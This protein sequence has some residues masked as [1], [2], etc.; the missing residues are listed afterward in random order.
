[1]TWRQL[2]D[3]G[4]AIGRDHIASTVY[5]IVFAYAGASLPSLLLFELYPRPF[6]TVLTG[7]VVAEE[8]I[9]ILVGGIALVLAVPVTTAIGAI[10]AKAADSQAGLA[11]DRG[12][13]RLPAG[14]RL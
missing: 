13:R 14:L 2:F 5:T 9:R 6:W 1:M 4:M 10:V 12:G 8:V 7:S 3:R 11:A